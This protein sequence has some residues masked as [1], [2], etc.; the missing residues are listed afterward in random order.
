MKYNFMSVGQLIQNGYK[1]LM[2]ND[3]C[4]IHE[5]DGSNRLLAVFQMT[6]NWMFPL[7]IETCFSSQVSAAS[8]KHACTIVH[9]QPALRSMI[10]DPSKLWYLRYGH[11]GF[12][13]LNILSKKRMVDL[14]GGVLIL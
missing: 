1:V 7:R 8:P 2:K 11:L 10:E 3:K 9:L 13:I 6:K 4:I 12:S 14:L 5:K